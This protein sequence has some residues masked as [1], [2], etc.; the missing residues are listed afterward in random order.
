MVEA[1][2]LEKISTTI[3][4]SSSQH[5]PAIDLDEHSNAAW[6]YHARQYE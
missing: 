5:S 1:D 2:K 6:A 4:L 3:R